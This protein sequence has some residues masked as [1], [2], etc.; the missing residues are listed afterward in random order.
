VNWLRRGWEL[1]LPNLRW[2]KSLKLRNDIGIA[3]EPVK[4][5]EPSASRHHWTNSPGGTSNRLP[6]GARCTAHSCLCVD[7]KDEHRDALCSSISC[8]CSQLTGVQL[9]CNQQNSARTVTTQH[10]CTSHCEVRFF[11]PLL[12]QYSY[13]AISRSCLLG[14]LYEVRRRK[15]YVKTTLLCDPTAETKPFVGL[16]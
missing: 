15:S 7:V 6:T 14:V 5:F 9:E 12:P 13:Y 10:T 1:P 11:Q 3:A 2:S 4:I 8:D 16:S